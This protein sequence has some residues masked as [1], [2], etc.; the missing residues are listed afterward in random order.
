[1]T[2]RWR[3]RYSNFK[4]AHALLERG[5]GIEHPN[6]IE[7]QGIIQSF[8]FTFE[9]AWKTLKDYLSLQGVEAKFPREVIKQAFHYELIGDGEVWLEMLDSRNVLCHTYDEIMAKNALDKIRLHYQPQIA[10]LIPLLDA[11]V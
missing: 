1:M 9:L 6:E 3:Q 5:L 10:H 4:R 11:K 8:E 7:A 2:E